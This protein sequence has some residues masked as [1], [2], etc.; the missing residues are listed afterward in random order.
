VTIAVGAK[1]RRGFD[2]N[3]PR[4]REGKWVET[5]ASLKNGV[6]NA[7][8][9]VTRINPGGGLTEASFDVRLADGSTARWERSS[10]TV[11]RNKD[12]SAPTA[13]APTGRA[14]ETPQ[15]GAS[16]VADAVDQVYAAHAP[17]A[18]QAPAGPSRA[19]DAIAQVYAQP[20][21]E[22]G[23]QQTDEAWPDGDPPS[24][25]P[26]PDETTAALD[27]IPHTEGS[28]DGAGT[29]EDP[30]DVGD[31]LAR[32]ATL[33]AEGKHV[34]LRQPDQVA[35]L[36]DN[37]RGLVADAEARGER[38]PYYDLCKVSVPGTNLFCKQSKGIPRARMPQLSGAVVPGSPA[39]ARANAKGRANLGPDFRESLLARGIPV[40]DRTVKASHLRAS[41]AEL[42][43]VKV[44]DMAAAMRAGDI[45]EAAIFVT[46][47]GYIIDGHHRWAAKVALEADGVDVDMPVQMIDMEIGEAIDNA[48]AFSLSMGIKPK[49][50]AVIPDDVA[51][52]VETDRVPSPAASD[53][54]SGLSDLGLGDALRSTPPADQAQ[55]LIDEAT[56]RANSHARDLLARYGVIEPGVTKALQDAASRFGGRM[57]GL[58]FRLKGEDS[59]TRKIRDKS[60]LSGRT[61]EDVASKIGDAL[62][63]T[64][65]L[66]ADRYAD[67]ASATLDDFQTRGYTIVDQDN[68]W[69]EGNVYQG[70]NA[71]IRDPDGLMFEV[72]FHTPESFD[73]KMS[74]H[75]DYETVRDPNATLEERVAAWKRMRRIQEGVP[76]PPDVARVGNLRVYDPPKTLRSHPARR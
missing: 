34:R 23:A 58:N 38:T 51:A 49:A 2:T 20:G 72:Q 45:R 24:G 7:V 66:D 31:D 76:V 17:L 42:D 41:Q 56:A 67:G 37:L 54:I 5:G 53:G 30:V 43:G 3:Q 12:G 39:A 1:A 69:H 29:L 13:D 44:A 47:D 28:G 62:R 65:V 60:L 11:Q 57:E 25:Q 46:R 75:V 74:T 35:T 48:N 8:G 6:T 70:L 73:A 19:T 61:Q 55:T 64:V 32:A 14:P 50:G 22:G 40:E 26:L 15:D 59:L 68:S 33:L 4:D 18:R 27:V 71:V 21:A 36:L 52:L 9:T 10:V 16:R 63:Y